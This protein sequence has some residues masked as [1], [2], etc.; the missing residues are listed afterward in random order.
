MS[1]FSRVM[2]KHA[3]PVKWRENNGGWVGNKR[4][5]FPSWITLPYP[6]KRWITEE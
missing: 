2:E 3:N 6:Y 5:Q 4:W 1:E